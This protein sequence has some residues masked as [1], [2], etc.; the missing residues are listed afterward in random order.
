MLCHA[1]YEK[2]HKLK[3]GRGSR[4]PDLPLA[5]HA[6]PF[7]FVGSRCVCMESGRDEIANDLVELLPLFDQREVPGVFKHSQL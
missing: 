1:M 7:L 2:C 4:T 5:R 3:S 6:W